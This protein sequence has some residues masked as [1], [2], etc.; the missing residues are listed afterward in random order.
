MQ[1]IRS[2]IFTLYLGA[3]VLIASS[4]AIPIVLCSA[5]MARPIVQCWSRIT[6][7]ALKFITGISYKIEGAEYIPEDGAII[8]VNHQSQWETIALYAILPNPVAILKKE[9][10][11]IPLYGWWVKR[12]GNIVVDRKGGATALRAMRAETAKILSKGQQILIFPEGTR[13]PVGTRL[14]FHSGIAGIYTNADAPCIPVAHNSGEHW[15]FPGIDKVP[16]E[17]TLRFL[18]PITPGLN[19]KIFLETLKSQIENARPDLISQ[20]SNQPENP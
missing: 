14:P 11:K 3:S 8:A 7:R 16:G 19:R 2:I 6:L 4:I 20:P 5:R 17:I 10:L 9:L 13:S 18:P 15:R 12:V 1:R